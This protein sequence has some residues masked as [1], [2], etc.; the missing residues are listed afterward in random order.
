MQR[1]TKKLAT[2]QKTLRAPKDKTNAFGKFRYRSCEDIL[3]A[4]K[5]IMPSDCITYC[6]TGI[7]NGVEVLTETFSDGI[8]SCSA[9]IIMPPVDKDRKGMSIEQVYGCRLSYAR[10][11]ALCMLYAIDDSK[12]DPD[13]KDNTYKRMLQ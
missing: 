6:S 12:D 8:S 7:I 2:I 3:E 4:L 11:Y 5:D 13:S 1:L 9:T 10:K